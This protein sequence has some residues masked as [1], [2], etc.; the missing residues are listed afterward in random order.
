M[1]QSLGDSSAL[2]R[3]YRS[4]MIRNLSIDTVM[5]STTPLTSSTPVGIPGLVSS[6]KRLRSSLLNMSCR[7]SRSSLESHWW[8]LASERRQGG[9]F[10]ATAGLRF[11]REGVQDL[12][13]H[14]GGG[15]GTGPP[16][17]GDFGSPSPLSFALAGA[18][19]APG[20]DHQSP[21]L[22]F[23]RLASSAVQIAKQLG[24]DRSSGS[25]RGRVSGD[26][27]GRLPRAAG[28]FPETPNLVL[29]SAGIGSQPGGCPPVT[30][31]GNCLDPG[32]PSPPTENIFGDQFPTEKPARFPFR[33]RFPRKPGPPSEPPPGRQNEPPRR[34]PIWPPL[35]PPPVPVPF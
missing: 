11:I 10:F 12:V 6:L 17:G 23:L 4:P 24:G 14:A 29:A 3:L 27:D 9:F 34:I 15:G 30:V 22:N 16:G 5:S 32:P 33:P 18:G 8:L 31:I 28:D 21:A 19:A 1:T 25:R 7:S 35:I 20:D 13:G 2:I 26:D